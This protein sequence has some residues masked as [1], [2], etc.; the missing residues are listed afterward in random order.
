MV[1]DSN[2]D[3]K[4]N[5]V[6]DRIDTHILKKAAKVQAQRRRQERAKT[7]SREENRAAGCRFEN[8]REG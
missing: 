4:R 5:P 3:G 8:I 2:G 7:T 6:A 1:R